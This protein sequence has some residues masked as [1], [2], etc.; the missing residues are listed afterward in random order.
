MFS[1]Y[2]LFLGQPG[3]SQGTTEVYASRFNDDGSEN[4]V[5]IDG[6]QGS[7]P[8]DLSVTFLNKTNDVV[9]IKSF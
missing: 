7:R 6:D 8:S 3:P 2:D 5:P 9:S 4:V 1:H